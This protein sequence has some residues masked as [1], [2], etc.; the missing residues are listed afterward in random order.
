MS[1]KSKDYLII[2]F[3]MS[4][5]PRDP[6]YIPVMLWES[7]VDGSATPVKV[8]PATG[9]ILIEV[10]GGWSVITE[11]TIVTVGSPQ[12]PTFLDAIA[13]V[14]NFDILD[15][16]TVTILLP[17]GITNAPA[18][19]NSLGY[20]TALGY[21]VLE[22]KWVV[23]SGQPLSSSYASVAIVWSLGSA[24]VTMGVTP[25]ASAVVGW[26]LEF[27]SGYTAKF[28]KWGAWEI[29]N[30]TGNVITIAT[31]GITLPNDAWSA[32]KKIRFI[33]STL[34]DET[35][36]DSALF[37]VQTQ[38]NLIS[39][40]AIRWDVNAKTNQSVGIYVDWSGTLQIGGVHFQNYYAGIQWSR[41]SVLKVGSTCS[42][43]NNDY[44]MYGSFG[45]KIID[46]GVSSG[47]MSFIGNTYGTYLES[48]SLY[49]NTPI[50]EGNT[51]DV[52]AK[53][54]SDVKITDTTFLTDKIVTILSGSTLVTKNEIQTITSSGSITNLDSKILSD[55][56]G[57]NI[58]LTLP[59]SATSSGKLFNIKKIDATANTVTLQWFGAETIDGSNTQIIAFPNVNLT[60]VSDG[61]S[62]Y[63]I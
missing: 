6:N 47:R 34:L 43:T 8:D 59:P 62:W 38:K 60:I 61:I 10:S 27:A 35:E 16:V 58:V 39:S 12:Y 22:K 53:N 17:S 29:T 24:T 9:A 32:S 48:S 11:N 20:R 13:A 36:T 19:S 21:S 4:I 25:P 28:L 41:W 54:E 2:I 30:I 37:S 49:H 33:P 7:T 3:I 14:S 52:Y 57:W 5:F 23:L 63:I 15:G 56:T 55:A 26:S 42:F 45:L 51:T 44:G 46:S 31:P 40:L 1:R 50:Y 18:P